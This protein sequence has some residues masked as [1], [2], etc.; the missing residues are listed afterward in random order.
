[1]LILAKGTFRNWKERYVV[2]RTQHIAYYES[3][4]QLDKAEAELQLNPSLTVRN[5]EC[6]QGFGLKIATAQD[7]LSIALAT[8]D[9]RDLWTELIESTATKATDAMRANAVLLSADEEEALVVSL[10]APIATSASPS[11]KKQAWGN[12]KNRKHFILSGK[13]LTVHP[14][15]NSTSCIEDFYE[16]GDDAVVRLCDDASRTIIL[17]QDTPPAKRGDSAATHHLAIQFSVMVGSLYNLMATQNADEQQYG[18]WKARLLRLLPFATAPSPSKP[19]APPT[20]TAVPSAPSTP[21]RTTASSQKLPPPVEA[22]ESEHSDSDAESHDSGFGH[23]RHDHHDDSVQAASPLGR[24]GSSANLDE[25]LRSIDIDNFSDSHSEG[26]G[27]STEHHHHEPSRQPGNSKSPVGAPRS[28][29]APRTPLSAVSHAEEDRFSDSH[30][31]S[32]SSEGSVRHQH[33]HHHHKGAPHHSPAAARRKIAA[34]SARSDSEGSE[35]TSPKRTPTRPAVKSPAAA[36]AVSAPHSAESERFSDSH[37]EGSDES[38]EAGDLEQTLSRGVSVHDMATDGNFSDSHSEG[39]EEGSVDTAPAQRPPAVHPKQAAPASVQRAAVAPPPRAAAT[40]ASRLRPHTSAEQRSDGESSEASDDDH[41]LNR[42]K[43]IHELADGDFSDSHSEGSHDDHVLGRGVSVHD[44]ATDGNFSDSHSEESDEESVEVI[45]PRQ[46]PPQQPPAPAAASTP[47]VAPPAGMPS[48]KPAIMSAAEV[49]QERFSDSH[50]EADSSFDSEP[51]N[52]AAQPLPKGILAADTQHE[53][54]NVLEAEASVP[55]DYM[56]TDEASL[57]Q[58]EDNSEGYSEHDE[59][60]QAAGSGAADNAAHIGS[61]SLLHQHIAANRRPAAH[62][63]GSMLVELDESTDEDERRS[64]DSGAEDESDHKGVGAEVRVESPSPVDARGTAS[65]DNVIPQAS[66]LRVHA[67]DEDSPF[68]SPS[69]PSAVTPSVMPPSA[70]VVI[71]SSTPQHAP[72]V[73][74]STSQEELETPPPAPVTLADDEKP[75]LNEPP[76]VPATAS[77]AASSVEAAKLKVPVAKSKLMQ[78]ALAKKA[79]AS[80][81]ASAQSES[82]AP[83]AVE[84]HEQQSEPVPDRARASSETF[85]LAEDVHIPAA[86]APAAQ[87]SVVAEAPVAIVPTATGRQ[88]SEPNLSAPPAAVDVAAPA[89][90]AS[91]AAAAPSVPDVAVAQ[92]APAV[93]NSKAKV[94]PAKSKLMQKALAKKTAAAEAEKAKLVKAAPAPVST[95]APAPAPAPAAAPA[96][97]AKPAEPAAPV[98]NPPA[99]AHAAVGVC[100]VA[101]PV[102]PSAAAPVVQKLPVHEEVPAPAV[103]HGSSA[104]PLVTLPSPPPSAAESLRRPSAPLPPVVAPP[105]PPAPAPPVAPSAHEGVS[106]VATD[107][108]TAARRPSSGPRKATTTSEVP[109]PPPPPL[110]SAATVVSASNSSA[111]LPIPEAGACSPPQPVPAPPAPSAPPAAAAHRRPSAATGAGSEPGL[112]P[113]PVPAPPAAPPAPAAKAHVAG[114]VAAPVPPPPAPSERRPSAPPAE[115]LATTIPAPP[116]A[117]MAPQAPVRVPPPP[118]QSGMPAPPSAPQPPIVR[119]PS[120]PSRPEPPSAPVPVPPPAPV[121]RRPSAPQTKPTPPPAQVQPPAPAPPAVAAPVTTVG[122]AVAPPAPPTERRP[123]AQAS[124]SVPEPPAVRRSSAPSEADPS[125]EPVLALPPAPVPPPAPYA[126]RRPSAPKAKLA[127]APALIPPPAPAPPVIAPAAAPESS[128]APVV[129]PAERRPSARQSKVAPPVP[130]PPMVAQDS[131][132]ASVPTVVFSSPTEVSTDSTPPPPVPVALSTE[133]R[134]SAPTKRPIS[135]RP[136]TPLT[137]ASVGAQDA[138]VIAPLACQP[139]VDIAAPRLVAEPLVAAAFAS[140]ADEARVPEPAMSP[141]VIPAPVMSM[142]SEE[143]PEDRAPIGDVSAPAPVPEPPRVL[144]SPQQRQRRTA[145]TGTRQADATESV[146]EPPSAVQ[147]ASRS[148]QQAAVEHEA[149]SAPSPITDQTGVPVAPAASALAVPTTVAEISTSRVAASAATGESGHAYAQDEEDD[150][151]DGSSPGPVRMTVPTTDYEDDVVPT[152][153]LLASADSAVPLEIPA[154]TEPA[155]EEVLEPGPSATAAVNELVEGEE[156]GVPA[157]PQSQAPAPAPPVSVCVSAPAPPPAPPAPMATT[158]AAPAPPPPQPRASTQAPAPPVLPAHATFS[159][160][161]LRKPAP[162]TELDLQINKSELLQNFYLETRRTPM[163]RVIFEQYKSSDLTI[164]LPAMQRLCYD[165]GVC[166]SATDME[167]AVRN[168]ASLPGG[169]MVYEDFTAWWVENEA[170]R[171]IKCVTFSGGASVLQLV[172]VVALLCSG[173]KLNDPVFIRKNQAVTCFKK[174]D[175]ELR[176]CIH[177][178][179]FSYVFAMLLQLEIISGKANWQAAVARLDPERREVIYLAPFIE[180]VNSVSLRCSLRPHP[181]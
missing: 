101:E 27:E 78:K 147:P 9:E 16:L 35:D 58:S 81:A 17:S 159:P 88:P 31:E 174:F 89:P 125:A 144:T 124:I 140:P 92:P 73:A 160:A 70:P 170:V 165:F 6:K 109:A 154:G 74:D 41:G 115:P 171:Y 105:P 64:E 2:L 118:P 21:L 142:Q 36:S 108:T 13:L 161:A 26:S 40:A 32:E 106:T 164:G 66:T 110:A 82:I 84:N 1:M 68:V 178:E 38:S 114:N 167:D 168:Y 33:H 49:E 83:A 37:S 130:A 59:V 43:S 52:R 29:I 75:S 54:H 172:F 113:P 129:P 123:S 67:L 132:P 169:T 91:S 156:V 63:R 112:V 95:S 139:A 102:Q 98:K 158:V 7:A 72:G 80:Q 148:L 163:A 14:D 5:V 141:P 62:R 155:A 79:A 60:D 131:V 77:A 50:S 65:F 120:T 107:P 153:L 181:L 180:W 177:V 48:R 44:L 28:P 116:V 19:T 61:L 111:T 12:K 3:G 23:H 100:R 175:P 25:S 24:Q 39:S 137:D 152:G 57:P 85:S 134:P 126:E 71:E 76:A 45:V 87:D 51:Q 56:D 55:E 150:E 133:R 135:P 96:T 94:P 90:P 143:E 4:V 47:V 151:F 136:E 15:E 53:S 93:D 119:R 117:T 104:A 22:S 20:A 69:V 86:S 179:C 11:P 127:A 176:G 103:D 46:T 42:S 30:S 34:Q 157:P 162:N 173:V 99:T 166:M 146:E 145:I 10:S 122:S 8:E 121:E 128:A 97:S 138:L 149:K 18:A